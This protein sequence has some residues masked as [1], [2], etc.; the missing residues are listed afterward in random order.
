MNLHPGVF[1]V[2]KTRVKAYKVPGPKELIIVLIPPINLSVNV[3]F[4]KFCKKITIQRN[5]IYLQDN[6][7]KEITLPFMFPCT[8]LPLE[9]ARKNMIVPKPWKYA[10]V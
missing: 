10:S 6:N 5:N 7:I 3:H 2:P 4:L 1:K 9:V 8:N